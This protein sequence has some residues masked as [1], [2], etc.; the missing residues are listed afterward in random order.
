MLLLQSR[1]IHTEHGT[2]DGYLTVAGGRITA[3]APGRVPR[4]L[5]GVPR[6]DATDGRIIPGMIDMHIHGA[7]GWPVEGVG[8]A[9]LRR[10][11]RYLA[12]F[13]VTGFLASASARSLP[14][15]E[16]C[17]DAVRGA[18]D[19]ATTDGAAILGVHLEGPFLSPAMK[20]AMNPEL[21]R[22]PSIPDMERLLARPGHIIRRVTLAPE[23][24]GALELAAFL[25]AHGVAVAGGHTDA[26]YDQTVAAI[27]AGVRIANH[28][29]NA[30]KG[31]HHREPG[32]H[33]AYMT[34]S[35][36]LCEVICD[37]L[38]VHPTA[39]QVLLRTA[40]P[41]RVAVISDAIPAAGMPPGEYR[42]LGRAVRLDEQGFSR[43]AGGTI[44]GSTRLMLHGLRNLIEGLAV[45]WE[46][47][48]HMTAFTA[49]R[50][51]GLG[52]RKGS[53][54]PGKDADLVV[55]GPDWRVR[56]SIVGG[57]IVRRPDDPDPELNPAFL[58]ARTAL[59]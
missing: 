43:L 31:L 46:D 34:D 51:L 8:P 24:P 25:I 42:L 16:E 27:D 52:A 35:R 6:I 59:T 9:E 56:W 3:V 58:A 36:V 15:L 33:G 21:F 32:A 45:S 1:A 18:M 23:L 48:V 10:L 13:G 7:G 38:H 29:Y 41:D 39:L 40:G 55:L 50:A 12:A 57:Q 19:A 4:N 2:V 30:M 17:L 53:L 5:A 28:T 47:A 11:A 54:T 20:G 49:A 37:F 26:T 14:V 22:A 44:A